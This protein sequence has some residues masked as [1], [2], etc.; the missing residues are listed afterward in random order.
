MKPI[1]KWAGGKSRL[2]P[3]IWDAFGGPCEGTYFEP[4]AGS[5]SVFLYRR[6]KGRVGKAV[7]SDVNP[8]LM[9]VHR[10]LRD[11]VDE[12]IREIE[13][14][15]QGDWRERYYDVR[16]AFNAGP[17][18]GPAHAARFIWLNRAGFNGLYRENRHGDLNVPIG[19]YTKLS[20]PEPAVFWN[21]HKLLKDAE[22]IDGGFVAVMER[23]RAKDQVYC[24]PPYVPLSATA[25]FTAY[26]REPFGPAEQ[27]GLAEL[28]ETAA[29]RGARV[30][31]SNHDVPIVCDE[32]YPLH[33][34]FEMVEKPM[35]SR[36]ISRNG[37][38]RE[39]VSEVIAAI[40]PRRAA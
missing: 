27:R 21:V 17:H 10:A 32:L 35:V 33:R 5:L 23:V 26:S 20:V 9:A 6:S 15:P 24:D 38:H 12:T 28:A 29:R 25:N 3:Q 31:L 36:A 37:A 34:G 40:G 18:E 39:R 2:A 13:R 22:L 16:T 30:V 4:F 1:L 14:L 7:L 8:K 19:S 11:H